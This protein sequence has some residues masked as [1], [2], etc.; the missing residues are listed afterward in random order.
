MWYWRKL[1]PLFAISFGIGGAISIWC[2]PWIEAHASSLIGR[3]L[4]YLTPPA[5]IF[6]LGLWIIV[7]MIYWCGAYELRQR[8]DAQ[9]KER[10]LA[11][12]EK[13]AY[14]PKFGDIL[15]YVALAEILW[16]KMTYRLHL[17]DWPNED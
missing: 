3:I 13:Q 6:L 11:R 5:L 8:V 17:W 7:C 9:W 10:I 16:A 1:G 14:H 15:D 12:L 2:R 4:L